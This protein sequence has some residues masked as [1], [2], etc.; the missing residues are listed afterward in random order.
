VK[1][2]G[3][4]FRI[5]AGSLTIL[6]FLVRLAHFRMSLRMAAVS[7]AYNRGS[8]HRAGNETRGGG[9]SPLQ[10]AY[11]ILFHLIFVSEFCNAL[12]SWLMEALYIRREFLC[13]EERAKIAALH[14][15]SVSACKFR[16][17]TSNL[18]TI[19]SPPHNFHSFF[20]GDPLTQKLS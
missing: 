3:G 19:Y 16:D 17:S 15:S 7:R 1:W 8:L 13:L 9:V 2:G 10:L 14:F 20:T 18:D 4:A 12:N 5:S 6:R 11:L